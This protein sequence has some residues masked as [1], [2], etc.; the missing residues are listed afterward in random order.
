MRETERSDLALA[1]VVQQVAS[2]KKLPMLTLLGTRLLLWPQVP[3][4]LWLTASQAGVLLLSQPDLFISFFPFF[5][6]SFFM[7]GILPSQPLFSQGFFHSAVAQFP[8]IACTMTVLI[9]I[10]TR[11]V[12]IKSFTILDKLRK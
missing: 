5:F 10:K 4:P 9:T 1:K 12:L 7:N 6:S 2:G 3:G 11:N 8:F